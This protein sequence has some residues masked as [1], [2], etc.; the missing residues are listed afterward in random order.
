M[1]RIIVDLG[2]RGRLNWHALREEEHF[3]YRHVADKDRSVLMVGVAHRPDGPRFDGRGCVEDWVYGALPYDWDQAMTRTAGAPE[4]RAEW[5]V[6][7]WVVEWSSGRTL[8]H[9]RPDARLQAEV[10]VKK[11]WAAVAPAE[12]APTM[13][14]W[15][16]RTSRKEYIDRVDRLMT[17]IQRGDIYEVNYCV[18]RTARDPDFDPFAAFRV[19]LER[20][21]PPFA[22]FH[23]NG[24]L[25]A[26][27]ASPERFLSFNGHQVTAQPMKG[28]RP[29]YP[30]EVADRAAVQELMNDPKERSENIMALDVMRND[31]SRVAAERSVVVEALC[32]VQSLPRVHQMTSTV[33]ACLRGGETPYSALRAAYPMASMTGAPKQRSMELIATAES[34]P[35]GRFS[36][37]LGFFAPDGTGDFNVVIR[38]IFVDQGTGQL[39]LR[40]GSAITALCDPALEWEE[41]RLKARSVIDALA[42]A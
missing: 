41:C 26:L 22:A 4:A 40:T 6:P 30:E 8:L 2:E 36:G 9:V 25:F 11:A 27:C 29:R 42:D 7:N 10:W 1:E 17:H 31:L 12:I 28:T 38:T 35:R 23:R 15:K 20:A 39:S 33:T 21:R 24:E 14:D 3:L 32:A 37:S 13:L 34:S 16:E 5:V 18:E 19:L